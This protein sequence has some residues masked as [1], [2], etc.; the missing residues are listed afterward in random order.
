MARETHP[1]SKI[2]QTLALLVIDKHRAE[3]NGLAQTILGE[4]PQLDQHGNWNVDYVA[5]TIS[6]EVPDI[7]PPAEPSPTPE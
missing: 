5:G 1:I 2:A 3:L 7:A 6:R 4:M